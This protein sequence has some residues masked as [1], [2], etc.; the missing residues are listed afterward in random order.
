MNPDTAKRPSLT[1]I[2]LGADPQAW[3]AAGFTVIGHALAVGGVTI[4]FTSP[5]GGIECLVFDHLPEGVTDLDGLPVKVGP[6]LTEATHENGVYSIDQVVIATPEF[7]RTAQ[8]MRD[9]G[10]GFK[11]EAVR[12]TEDGTQVRQGFVRSGDAVLEVVHAEN[13]TGE[14]AHGWGVGF[15][16]ADLDKAIHDLEGLIGPPHEAVQPGRRIATIRRDVNLG[17]PVVLMDPEPAEP[18]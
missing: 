4:E 14:H 6:A 15:I 10:L 8:V 17:I 18:A 2:K 16:T 9:M 12:E 1:G 13:V 5:V 7:D 3:E 11:R